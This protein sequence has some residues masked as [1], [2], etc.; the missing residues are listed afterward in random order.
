MTTIVQPIQDLINP[1]VMWYWGE[2]HTRAVQ[3]VKALICEAPVLAHF[4][5][6]KPL[7]IQCD[8]AKDGLESVLMQEDH[9]IAFASRALTTAETTYAQVENELLSV[10]FALETFHQ[11]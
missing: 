1:Q 5:A 2:K 11:Y 9:P 8:A 10:V 6:A 4:D 7:V 3:K